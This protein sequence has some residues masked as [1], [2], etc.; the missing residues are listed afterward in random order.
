LKLWE[1][2]Q[3]YFVDGGEWRDELDTTFT[4]NPNKVNKGHEWKASYHTGRCAFILKEY[5]PNL[6]PPT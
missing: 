3:T 2:V 4:P 6:K 1:F 5:C